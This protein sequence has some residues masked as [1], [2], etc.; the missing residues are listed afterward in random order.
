M[1][2]AS[3]RIKLA[4]A[5]M[6]AGIM[7][8]ICVSAVHLRAGS[9]LR[10]AAERKPAPNFSLTDAKDAKISLSDFKGK[11]VL[12]NFWATWCHGCK[13]G[14]PWYMEFAGKYKD[15]GLAVI[16]ISMDDDGWKAV[17]PYMEEKKLNYTIVIGNNSLA[18]QYG[19]D[20]M[21]LSVLIDRDGRIADSHSGVVDKDSWEQEIQKLLQEH[22]KSASK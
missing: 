9:D 12:V 7:A 14:I 11:V 13:Q 5:L 19:L 1:K 20:S 6:L 10:A 3:I 17:K 21:P 2:L 15:S 4:H 18:D 8:A 22:P 16:G